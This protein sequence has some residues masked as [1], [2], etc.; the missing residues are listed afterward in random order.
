MKRNTLNA[1]VDG[2]L[3]LSGTGLLVTGLFLAF[4]VPAGSNRTHVLWGMSRHEWGDIHLWLAYILVISA[5]VHV[6]LHWTWIVA[7]VRRAVIGRGKGAP[8][9]RLRVVSGCVAVVLIVGLVGGIWAL[10]SD[11][12]TLREGTGHGRRGANERNQAPP[13]GPEAESSEQKRRRHRAGR[14][15]GEAQSP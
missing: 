9:L 7:F 6:V 11:A 12:V 2:L 10:A 8:S 4:V 1:L 13:A 15:D 5:V 3:A 14:N